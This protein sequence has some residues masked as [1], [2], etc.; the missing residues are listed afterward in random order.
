MS[1]IVVK[2]AKSDS[3]SVIIEALMHP[4]G[5]KKASEFIERKYK[6]RDDVYSSLTRAYRKGNIVKHYYDK[7]TY[8]PIWAIFEVITLGQFGVF[9]ELLDAPVKLALSK[10]IGIPIKY[11]TDGAVLS[12]LIYMLQDL[13]NAIAHNG[14][15]FDARYHGNRK[16]DLTISSWLQH[17]TQVKGISFNSLTDDIVFI[18]MLMK[19]LKFRKPQL[20][21]FIRNVQSIDSGLY[22]SI[23][24]SL[25]MKILSSDARTKY[26][27]TEK[28]LR[29]K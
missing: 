29:A 24:S 10:V 17:E 13:R 16:V 28:Y 19:K 4:A 25:Y 27:A 23:G 12:K 21:S 2:K 11:N 26:K 20:Y 9:V 15:I 8:V 1:E 5:H 6:M 3:F 18:M 22:K 7:D 14:V